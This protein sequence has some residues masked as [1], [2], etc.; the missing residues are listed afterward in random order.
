MSDAAF[1]E[2][3]FLPVQAA[4]AGVPVPGVRRVNGA[5]PD[6]RAISALRFGDADVEVV[7]LHGAGLNA[8]TWD[9]TALAVGRPALAVDLPGHGDSEW[10][11]DADYSPRAIATD[12][13]PALRGWVTRP[14]VLVGQSL[15]GLTAAAIARL[16]PELVRAL[17]V[18]DIAPGLDPAGGAASIRAFFAGPTDWASRAELVDRALA[19]GLGG[20]R[21]AAERGVLL[22]S[23]VRADGRVEWKHHF[24]RIANRLAADS[25]AAAAAD[26]HQDAIAAVLAESGW[27]DLRAVDAPLT[28]V[29]GERGF[30]SDADVAA[31]SARLPTA[32]IVTVDSG[33]NVQEE[34]PAELAR[35][36]RDAD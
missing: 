28:L 23:R 10:R 27:D 24:A 5:S 3:S 6:G 32:G 36:I 30:L 17:I 34:Q 21:T 29:R 35:I 31:F 4:E 15:G 12:L 20:D 16:A 19:F 11:D 1:D 26:A 8:H 22:N 2:F 7:L 18:V 33:H 13:L 14:V 25:D 9:R